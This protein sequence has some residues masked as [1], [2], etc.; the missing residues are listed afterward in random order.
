MK[1]KHSVASRT[2]LCSFV[3]LVLLFADQITKFYACYY[4]GPS[5]GGK[6]IEIIPGFLTLRYDGNP[7]IAF[8]IGVGNRLFM[9]T[10]MV[11][12][13]ILIVFIILL[14]YAIFRKN[15]PVRMCLAVVEAGAIGNFLDRLFYY[16]SGVATVRDFLDFG[17]FRPFAWLGSDF[18]FGICNVADLCISFGAVA[19][20]FIVLFIGPHAVFPLTK[21]W[22]EQAKAEE[23]AEERDKK[24]KK[25]KN[26]KAPAE[27][28]E[29]GDG[30]AAEEASNR[31][32]IL[33]GGE[34]S[35]PPEEA[36]ADMP[37][38]EEGAGDGEA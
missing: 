17:E 20:L 11:F 32:D 2:A 28:P 9:I 13:A 12:T 33:Q 26:M 14:V 37:A 3:A 31:A 19:L 35:A 5:S 22:R 1:K 6:S 29:E 7:G 36:Q 23:A 27:V 38:A 16:E 21:K 15:L 18:N 24:R 34:L 8:G 30:A 25:K 4:L 10:V